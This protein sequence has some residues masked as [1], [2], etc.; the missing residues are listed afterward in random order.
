[1][2]EYMV[3]HPDASLEQLV[4]AA[5]KW[6]IPGDKIPSPN[7]L[8]LSRNGTLMVIEAAKKLGRWKE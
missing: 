6:K 3:G 4:E 2:R 7:T 5:K 8:M 1:V